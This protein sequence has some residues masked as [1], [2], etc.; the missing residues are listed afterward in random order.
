[1]P[2]G[3]KLESHRPGAHE[4]GASFSAEFRT[5][6]VARGGWRRS[7]RQVVRGREDQ[8]TPE[9]F[10]WRRDDESQLKF[11]CVP[12]SGDMPTPG[13]KFGDTERFLNHEKCSLSPNFGCPTTR[14]GAS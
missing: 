14:S 4:S 12:C 5:S 1:M 11:A 7:A 8:H 2:S 3:F 6:R 10:A 9:F 13:L